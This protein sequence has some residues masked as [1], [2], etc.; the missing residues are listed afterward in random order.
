MSFGRC[1]SL[2][3]MGKLS[4]GFNVSVDGYTAADGDDIA[5]SA[6]G[7]ELHQYWNDRVREIAVSL[8][9]RKLYELMSAY[10]PTADQVPDVTP[11]MA[12]FARVWR[13]TPKVVFSKTLSTVDWNSRLERGD[14]VTVA[15]ELKA[16]TDGI[17]EIGGPTLAA[18]LVRAGL[19]D[20]YR[21]VYHPTAVGSGTPLFPRLEKW[22]RLNLVENRTFSCGAV[23]LRYEAVRDSPE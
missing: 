14:V 13:E 2:S 10:W 8:Y 17:I 9:G 18:P 16:S 12:D 6:P 23:L 21:I 15:K 5:F 7:D 4:Y 1:G 20:E 11:V 22:V 19:V 3:I